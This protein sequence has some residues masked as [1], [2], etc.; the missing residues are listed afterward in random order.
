MAEPTTST[1]TTEQT[2]VQEQAPASAPTEQRETLTLPD[3]GKSLLGTD[4]PTEQT[5]TETADTDEVEAEYQGKS[6]KDLIKMHKEAVKLALSKNQAPEAYDFA[7]VEK[8]GLQF[9]DDAHRDTISKSLKDAGI[10]QA[11]VAKLAP[12]YAD[13]A[14]RGFEIGKQ[15]ALAAMTASYGEP[16]ARDNELTL[17]KKDWGDE[18]DTRTAALSKWAAA[19]VPPE[20]DN[21]PWN[22][23][24]STVKWMYELMTRD[25]GADFIR[26]NSVD[27][28]S[29]PMSR[30]NEITN[31]PEYNSHMGKGPSL[32][33]EA[34]RLANQVALRKQ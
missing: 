22:R 4:A 9:Q 3:H 24:A 25:R 2:S 26:E 30:L 19:N 32:R 1:E 10:S 20:M 18:F 31:D 27:V 15:Q 5:S 8:L 6:N 12:L 17:L 28:I 14:Q 29:D 33:A 7:D 21:R 23:S 11:H 13:A 16:V 34:D